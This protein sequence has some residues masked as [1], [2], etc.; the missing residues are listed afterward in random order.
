VSGSILLGAVAAHRDHP[1][2]VPP[3]WRPAHG[4]AGGCS[5]SFLSWRPSNLP[6][7]SSV[8]GVR[9]KQGL[10]VSRQLTSPQDDAAFRAQADGP[11][12]GTIV[13]ARPERK[14]RKRHWHQQG[15]VSEMELTA[16]PNVFSTNTKPHSSSWIRTTPCLASF[17]FAVAL[18]RANDPFLL[19]AV[20]A[21]IPAILTPNHPAGLGDGE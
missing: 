20:L 4:Q 19:T 21:S 14:G 7:V 1:P 15:P 16:A 13:G 2:R 10:K 5:P 12:A 8:I 6:K 11:L 17:L 3:E 18:V 9:R